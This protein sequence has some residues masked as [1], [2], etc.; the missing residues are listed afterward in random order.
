MCDIHDGCFLS[1]VDFL[2]FLYT[3]CKINIFLYGIGRKAKSAQ[4]VLWQRA[5]E[6]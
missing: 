6:S 2:S 3:I 4:N 1:V 5:A